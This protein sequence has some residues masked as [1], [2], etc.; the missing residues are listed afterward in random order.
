MTL[1]ERAYLNSKIKEEN[2]SERHGFAGA[3]Q[4]RPKL[5][6]KEE[7]NLPNRLPTVSFIPAEPTQP[8]IILLY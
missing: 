2:T 8:L 7:C 6:E 3:L 4:I 5:K 1:R